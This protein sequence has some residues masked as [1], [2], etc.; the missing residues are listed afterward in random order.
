MFLTFCQ[1]YVLNIKQSRSEKFLVGQVI[2][3]IKISEITYVF[4]LRQIFGTRVW[5]LS[6]NMIIVHV[7]TACLMSIFINLTWVNVEIAYLK[8][9]LFG[10]LNH[11]FP[12]LFQ[13]WTWN[14]FVF[15]NL[16]GHCIT[17]ML[18]LSLFEQYI[19]GVIL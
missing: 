6:W 12:S 3:Y 19:Q 11:W 1:S 8:D 18:T 2:V 4:K 7:F 15:S 5:Q 17:Y 13:L 14:I 16:Y 9:C 10:F